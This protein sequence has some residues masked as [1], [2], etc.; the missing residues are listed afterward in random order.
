MEK[1][2]RK[3]IYQEDAINMKLRWQELRKWEK[4]PEFKSQPNFEQS[5]KE[6]K[7]EFKKTFLKL[8]NINENE[9]NQEMFE[10]VNVVFSA[11]GNPKTHTVRVDL[12]DVAQ[13]LNRNDISGRSCYG[14]KYPLG[15]KVTHDEICKDKNCP[16]RGLVTYVNLENLTNEKLA[17]KLR[18]EHERLLAY[19]IGKMQY[20]EREALGF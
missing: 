15:I 5:K 20:E 13:P 1:I 11:G 3:E 17:E 16:D 12:N 4:S 18:L 8:R 2:I 6:L 19:G 14:S 7:S 10:Q 9:Q